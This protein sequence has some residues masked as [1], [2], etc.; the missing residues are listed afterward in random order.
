[1]TFESLP[2]RDA[3]PADPGGIGTGRVTGDP[4]FAPRLP[5]RR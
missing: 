2:T 4:R 3:P 5:S 1:M